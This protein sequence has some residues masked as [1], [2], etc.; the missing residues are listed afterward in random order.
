MRP[1]FSLRRVAIGLW[2]AL[3]PL[4]IVMLNS[5][6]SSRRL[7]I[8]ILV[9][10][11]TLIAGGLV[12]ANR[13]KN[14]LFSASAILL[15]IGLFLNL[16]G[17]PFSKASLEQRYLT[18][19]ASYNGVPYVWGGESRRGIDCSGL[20][21]R[22]WQ[23]ALL[24]EGLITLNPTLVRAAIDLWWNDTTA[25]HI[26]QGYGGRTYTVTTC[27]SLNELDHALLQPG[28]M[29]VTASGGHILGYLGDS[30]WTE[31]DPL[32]LKVLTF[33]VPENTNAW[34]TTPMTI[35]RWRPLG[36]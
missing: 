16:P 2:L 28:D 15:G 25:Q 1:S 26:G 10:A 27:R 30:K 6:V 4:L 14:V 36:L 18:E 33:S 13:H 21:R 11:G 19:M 20:L 22:S 35:V 8:G 9:V 32:A 24:K 23:D 5:T 31:A 29:A 12:F 34:F 7:R 17:R 3:I